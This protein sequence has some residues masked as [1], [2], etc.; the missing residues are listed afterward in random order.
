MAS[1]QVITIELDGQK[2]MLRELSMNSMAFNDLAYIH[3]S[4]LACT[5]N[6]REKRLS[7]VFAGVLQGHDDVYLYHPER[8]GNVLL[9]H[10]SLDVLDE[11]RN[12]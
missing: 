2:D 12:A 10:Q 4:I 11:E 9:Q 7:D 8:G 1:V 5:A 3:S 6:M